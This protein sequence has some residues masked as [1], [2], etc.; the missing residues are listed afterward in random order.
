MSQV[1]C[2][3]LKK[4]RRSIQNKRR[5]MLTY[6]VML[7]QYNVCPHTTACTRA[8]LEHFKWELFGHPPYS[9]DLAWSDYHPFTYVKSWL[10]SWHFN[11]NDN[12]VEIIKTWLSSQVADFYDKYLSSDDDY[13]EK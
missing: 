9:P 13:I 8:L 11:N 3:M 6:G 2:E 7:L 5:G 12:L 4:L 10:G 1:Y